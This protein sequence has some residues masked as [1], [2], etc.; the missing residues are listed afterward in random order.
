MG[1]QQFLEEEGNFAAAMIA[2]K[3]G[4]D[5]AGISVLDMFGS[6]EAGQGV[7]ALTADGGDSYI[8]TLQ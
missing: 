7:L 8:K 5:D 1:L 2:M 3:E 4:A 6:I